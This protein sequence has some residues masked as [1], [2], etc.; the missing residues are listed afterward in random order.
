MIESYRTQNRVYSNSLPAPPPPPSS[1]SSCPG[2]RKSHGSPAVHA[3]VS[4]IRAIPRYLAFQ[5]HATDA[6]ILSWNDQNSKNFALSSSSSS[7]LGPVSGAP[8]SGV[9]SDAGVGARIANNDGTAADNVDITMV[10]IL[11]D[12][13]FDLPVSA[14][15]SVSDDDTD[16]D[17][18]NAHLDDDD[19]DDDTLSFYSALSSSVSSHS[20]ASQALSVDSVSSSTSASEDLLIQAF[21]LHATPYTPQGPYVPTSAVFSQFS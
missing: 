10:A 6:D 17:G 4:R 18:Q 19:D 12:D 13:G 21:T 2:D 8:V 7:F 16:I 11:V 5:K 9:V 14:S 3:P 15:A 1:S 20:I